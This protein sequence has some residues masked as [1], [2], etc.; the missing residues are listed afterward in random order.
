MPAAFIPITA[1]IAFAVLVFSTLVTAIL[2]RPEKWLSDFDQSFYITIAY[3][4]VHHGVF[5]N[6]VFD[7]VDS[8]QAAP[9]PGRFFAPVYPALVAG[10]MKLDPRFARAVD[11]SVEASHKKRDGA[12]CEVYALPM[13]ILHAALLAA[14]VLAIALTAELIFAGSLTFWLTGILATIALIPDVDLFSFVMTES[15]TFA[16]YSIAAFALIWAMREPRFDRILLAGCLFGVLTLTRVSYV[17]LAPVVALLVIINGRMVGASWLQITRCLVA[18]A[19]G[20]VTLVGPWAARNAMS[21]GRWGLTE[22]YGSATLIERFAFNDMTAREFV[23][24]FPYCLPQVG[25]PLVERVFGSAALERFNYATPRSFFAVGR[26]QRNKLAATHGRLDPLI[27]EI[28]RDEMQRNGW[29]HLLVSVPLAW[30]GMWIGGWLGLGL[31]PLFVAACFLARG[32]PRQLLLLYGA[33]ALVMLGVHAALANHYTR[34]NLI[35]IGPFAA[36]AAWMAVCLAGYFSSKGGER[37]RR[38]A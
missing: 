28:T 36:G 17:A 33:P 29:R 20:W 25:K 18:L 11:C 9:P 26:Q 35:L 38:R 12:T 15:A 7:D 2:F 22:E 27:A 16:F 23:L 4:I 5:S 31:V 19:V 13:H 1:R 37:L 8:T 24:A 32:R 3:D 21:V 30:C 10:A 34:Y 6:G 14:G